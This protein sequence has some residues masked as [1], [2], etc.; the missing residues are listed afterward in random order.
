MYLARDRS[1]TIRM[2]IH[3]LGMAVNELG[4][5]PNRGAELRNIFHTRDVVIGHLSAI[6]ADELDRPPILNVNM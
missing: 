1:T 4:T 6:F 3:L 2:P 5:K